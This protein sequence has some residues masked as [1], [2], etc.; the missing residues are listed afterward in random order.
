VHYKI[1]MSGFLMFA[2]G[3]RG[4]VGQLF[5]GLVISFLMVSL[6]IRVWP[7]NNDADNWLRFA[8]EVQIFQT[9]AVA[10]AL[11][12]RGSTHSALDALDTASSNY[13]RNLLLLVVYGSTL[14]D[15]LWLQWTL[16]TI[17]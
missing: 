16:G 1:V 5:C 11:K 3:G 17:G 10:L 8:A 7:Y 2:P 14:R 4:S 12:S 9:I 6:T 13:T 15:C